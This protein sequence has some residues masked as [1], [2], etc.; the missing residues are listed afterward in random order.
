MGIPSYFSHIVKSHREILKKYNY[1]RM[2]IHNL[3]MDC[4]S[5]IY[6]AVSECESNT[7]TSSNISSDD[8]E[9]KLINDVCD[10]IASYILLIK[11][12]KRLYIAFDGVA[13]VAKLNQQR[14]RRYK[15]GFESRIIN[16]LD[17]KQPK[18]LWNTV[19]ITPGTN[20]M[21]KLGSFVR[22]RFDKPS[23]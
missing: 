2:A 11:P 3:Y 1:N 9:E 22:N 18:P 10:K 19:A 23:E 13:P 16:K 15:S 20:F 5:L 4:N 7:D 6:D 17:S 12:K 14:N 21:S 8:F